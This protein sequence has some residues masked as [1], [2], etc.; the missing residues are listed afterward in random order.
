MSLF[1]PVIAII[2]NT[3]KDTFHPIVLT[4]NPLPGLPEGKPV[5]LMSKMHHT[6]GFKSREEAIENIHG[7]LFPQV[8]QHFIGEPRLDLDAKLEWDGDGNPTTVFSFENG[9]L[10]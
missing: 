1:N 6:A 4:E 8:N 5:R 9:R 3:T 7:K 2:R 10:S